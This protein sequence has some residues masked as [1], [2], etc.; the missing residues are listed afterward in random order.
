MADVER[1][2]ALRISRL[3]QSTNYTFHSNILSQWLGSEPFEE[4]GYVLAN[5]E[6]ER[7]R[8]RESLEGENVD[9]LPCSN[10][11]SVLYCFLQLEAFPQNVCQAKPTVFHLTKLTDCIKVFPLDLLTCL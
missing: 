2:Y 8:E 7:E 9:K 3:C 6:R 4:I 5:K 11:E 1:S 10:D